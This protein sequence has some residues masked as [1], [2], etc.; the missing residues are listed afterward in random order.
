MGGYFGFLP[1]LFYGRE[2][3]SESERVLRGVSFFSCVGGRIKT[4]LGFPVL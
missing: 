3:F 1:I 4:F 2:D